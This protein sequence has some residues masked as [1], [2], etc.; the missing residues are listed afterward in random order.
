MTNNIKKS[1]IRKTKN[2]VYFN[3]QQYCYTIFK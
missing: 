3:K 2:N 1:R